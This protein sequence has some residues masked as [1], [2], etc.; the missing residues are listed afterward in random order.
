MRRMVARIK[1]TLLREWHH[2]QG[3]TQRWSEDDAALMAAAVAYYLGLSLFPLLLVLLS[4]FGMFLRYTESGRDAQGELLAIV[5]TNLSGQL[6]NHVARALAQIEDKSTVSGPLGLL[7]MLLASLAGFAQFDRA[8]DRIWR[9]RDEG[10]GGVVSAIRD[11]LV[12]RGVAFLLLLASGLLIIL[13]FLTSLVLSAVETYTQT[14]VATPS[15]IWRWAHVGVTLLLNA[16]LFTL[17][18]RWLT[19]VD[20]RWGDAVRGAV[21]A[22]ILWEVG[23]IALAAYLLRSSIGS[24]YGVIGSF[25]AILLWCYYTV[26]VVFFGAEY[27]QQVR[28]SRNNASLPGQADA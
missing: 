27:I 26:A 7:G 19:K 13:I 3:A 15:Q 28:H 17:L 12:R 10:G 1:Q 22:A 21:L 2:L 25:I 18:Y 14:I 24:A 6:Q 23:R 20:V 4:G 11:I 5:E 8:F 16:L 9:A